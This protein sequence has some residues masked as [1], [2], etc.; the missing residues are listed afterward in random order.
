MFSSIDLRQKL[1]TL[2]SDVESQIDA[3]VGLTASALSDISSNVLTVAMAESYAADGAAPTLAQA[4]FAIQQFL[5]ER[6]VATTTVTVK[7]L[8]GSTSAMTFTLDDETTPTSIT[9]TT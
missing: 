6:S 7:K 2:L 4:V 8:D 1:Q 5:Q 3:G 9:R